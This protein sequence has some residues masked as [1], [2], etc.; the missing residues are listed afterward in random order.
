[1]GQNN[2]IEENTKLFNR[3]MEAIRKGMLKIILGIFESFDEKF[4]NKE[5]KLIFT[6]S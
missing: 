6:L 2:V 1:M 5:E 4:I 3:Y